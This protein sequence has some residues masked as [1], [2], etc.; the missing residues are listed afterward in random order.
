MHDADHRAT[1]P[2]PPNRWKLNGEH[3]APM[4]MVLARASFASRYRNAPAHSRMATGWPVGPS[5]V[6]VADEWD[7]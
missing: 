1:K 2:S 5:R 3:H 6:R 4:G 7:T